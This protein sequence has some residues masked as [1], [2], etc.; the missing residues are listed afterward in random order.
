MNEKSKG[1]LFMTSIL[2]ILSYNLVIYIA[3]HPVILFDVVIEKMAITEAVAGWIMT[4]VLLCMGTFG[5]ISSG[6]L[7]KLG[8]KKSWSVALALSGI[9]AFIGYAVGDSMAMM[10]LSRV[11]FGSG[12]GIIFVVVGSI[13]LTFYDEKGQ[14]KMNTTVGLSQFLGFMLAALLAVP[15]LEAVGGSFQKS[16]GVGGFAVVAVLVLWVIFGK[17]G[18]IIDELGDDAANVFLEVWKNNQIKLIVISYLLSMIPYEVLPYKAPKPPKRKRRR[19][20][21]PDEVRFE[22]EVPEIY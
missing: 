18:E 17:D 1:S 11:V 22:H 16:I 20:G 6:L 14:E 15:V 21:T 4:V 12:I 10:I 5:F 19:P 3:Y 13:I 2:V 8:I 7:R 9:G